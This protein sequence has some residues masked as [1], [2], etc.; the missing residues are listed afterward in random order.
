MIF[1]SGLSHIANGDLEAARQECRA[2]ESEL[3]DDATQSMAST[4]T[5]AHALERVIA[6]L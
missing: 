2:R 3:R 6:Q 4:P 1:A 5:Y